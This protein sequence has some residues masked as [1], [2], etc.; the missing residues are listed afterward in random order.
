MQQFDR[1][2]LDK[3]IREV[4]P[5][6]LYYPMKSYLLFG[7]PVKPENKISEE[8]VYLKTFNKSYESLEDLFSEVNEE[9][10]EVL[11]GFC[12]VQSYRIDPYINQILVS[13][14]TSCDKEKMERYEDSLI[15]YE[16]C[17][18]YEDRVLEVYYNVT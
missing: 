1:I 8:L 18:Q 7:K 6:R 16:E 11:S 3:A 17:K 13:C 10:S 9:V 12:G 2:K 14:K 5:K 4:V 15:K